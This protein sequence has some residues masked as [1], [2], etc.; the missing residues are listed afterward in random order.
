MAQLQDISDE[1]MLKAIRQG[2]YNIVTGHQSFTDVNGVTYTR[3]NLGE[4]ERA[5]KYYSQ[6]VQAK[7][8]GIRTMQVRF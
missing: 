2:I 3:A 7:T 5:E 6:K 8:N 1:E 4:L